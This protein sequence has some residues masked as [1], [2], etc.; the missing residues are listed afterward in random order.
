MQTYWLVGGDGD[1]STT[2]SRTTDSI[3]G[4]DADEVQDYD[5][6]V[7]VRAQT[8]EMPNRGGNTDKRLQKLINW[9]SVLISQF[10]G[11]IV[12]NRDRSGRVVAD[13]A[14]ILHCLRELSFGTIPVDQ[15]ADIID[16]PGS[17]AAPNEP[18]VKLDASVTEQLRDYV[19]Y[20]ASTYSDDNAFHNFEHVS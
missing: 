14:D 9:T 15:V 18:T 16:M 2:I 13:P 5:V 8:E 1:R 12:A 11:K 3:G 19:T 7:N 6:D 4:T 17:K 20:I 10:L